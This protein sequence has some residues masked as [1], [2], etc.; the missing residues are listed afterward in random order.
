[1]F[2]LTC[3]V[4]AVVKFWHFVAFVYS[5]GAG[6]YTGEQLSFSQKTAR[7]RVDNPD[8]PTIVVPRPSVGL[9]EAPAEVKAPA[10][11]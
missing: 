10:G 6:S 1:L 3:P 8:E 4:T 2:V 7:I 5:G 9:P 11:G